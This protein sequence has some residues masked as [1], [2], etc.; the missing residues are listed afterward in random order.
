MFGSNNLVV[1]NGNLAGLPFDMNSNFNSLL[2]NLNFVDGNFN[3]VVGNENEI[4]GSSNGVQ[5]D[6]VKIEGNG[7]IVESFVIGSPSKINLFD[8]IMR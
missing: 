4:I 2:G 8:S 3:A 6:N 1:G 7:N 5:G